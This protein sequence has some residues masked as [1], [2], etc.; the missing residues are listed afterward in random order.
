MA[1]STEMFA[2]AATRAQTVSAAKRLGEWREKA[3]TE[4]DAK[5]RITN[6]FI[7]TVL[8]M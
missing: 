5:N 8:L 6:R 4:R 7:N 1:T 3:R 2:V